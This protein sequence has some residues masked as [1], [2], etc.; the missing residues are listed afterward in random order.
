MAR[1]RHD[2][3]AEVLR[4]RLDEL[5]E[6][7]GVVSRPVL[8]TR[9]AQAFAPVDWDEARQ[10]AGRWEA[11]CRGLSAAEALG[12]EPVEGR[13]DLLRV[14]IEEPLAWTLPSRERACEAILGSLWLVP[15]VRDATSGRLATKGRSTLSHL[16]DHPRFGRDARRL[17]RLVDRGDAAGV[18][19]EVAQ[20]A[21]RGHLHALRVVSFFHRSEV[22]FLDI[23]TMGLFGGSPVIVCGFARTHADRIEVWQLVAARPEAEEALIRETARTLAAHP[24]LVTFNGRAFDYPYLC[25]RAAYYGLDPGEDPAHFDLLPHARRVWRGRVTDCRLGTLAREVLGLERR[26]DLS[27]SLVP[28]FYQEYLADP[29]GRVGLLAAIAAH[30]RD[31][32]IEMVRLF[33]RL[34]EE[35]DAA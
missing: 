28:A 10:L 22:L 11:S 13:D 8:D 29:R 33:A 27:G 3:I 26:D 21:G 12:G 23:E 6:R 15:G 7:D 35:A 30:N 14:R 2:E 20:R 1:D 4:R 31:D 17:C 34:V 16:V 9:R 5:R 19:A 32:M 25:Q 18:M 24:A